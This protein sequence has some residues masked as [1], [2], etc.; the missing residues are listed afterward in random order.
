MLSIVGSISLISGIVNLLALTAPL[1]MLQ[2]YDRVLVSRSIPTLVGLSILAGG[3]YIFQFLL[4]VI[5]SRVLIRIGEAFDVKWSTSVHHAIVTLPLRARLPGDGLQPLRD[6]D[7]VRVFLSGQGPTAFFD[8]PWIPLYLGIC[9]LFHF[10][11][12]VTALAGAIILVSITLLT[13]YLTKRRIQ[14]SVKCSAVRNALIDSARRNAEAV[15]VLGMSSRIRDRWSVV[16][17][18]YLSENRSIADLVGALGGLAKCLR[19]MLQSALLAVGAYLVVTEQTSAGV[20]IAASI[21]MGRALAP[22]D[23]AIAIWKPFLMAL[24]SWKR[25]TDLLQYVPSDQSVLELPPPKERLTLE[26]ISVVPPGQRK[27]TIAA[28]SFEMRAGHALGIIGGSGSGKTTLARAIVGAWELA[29][30]S[31]RLDGASLDQWDKDYLGKHIGYLPQSVELFNGTVA[32]NIARFEVNADPEKVIAAAKNAGAHE[33][34]LKFNNGYETQ[35]GEG[36]TTLSA[37]QRQRVAL[38]RALFDDPFLVVLD[39]PNAH[40]DAEGEFALIRAMAGI[41]A[42]HGIAIV[43]TH[44]PSAVELVDVVLIM[45]SGR[46]KSIG[47][48]ADVLANVITRTQHTDEQHLKRNNVHQSGSSLRPGKNAT[49][50]G[51]ASHERT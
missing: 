3:L 18:E 1:F 23:L 40:L 22:V 9:F 20:M 34:I 45:E 13:N 41:K 49:S 47:P 37:G 28:I 31:V 35:I 48:R 11:L 17:A 6:L 24:Q 44:R 12:G 14:D 46:L 5:R 19:I 29:S 50:G 51:G 39:E 38:A 25:I 32:E 7:N 26:A 42:R 10:W 36:G 8:L 16:N 4:D 15:R 2:V 30:G 43:I 21:M 27:P 33:L